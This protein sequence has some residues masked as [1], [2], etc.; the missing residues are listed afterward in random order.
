M[1]TA[2]LIAEAVTAFAI[3]WGGVFLIAIVG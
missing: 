3:I 2:E 1:K